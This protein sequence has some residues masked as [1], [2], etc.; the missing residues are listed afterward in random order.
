MAPATDSVM[1]AVSDEKAGVASAM[2]DVTRQVAGAVGV[3]V[4]GSLVASLYSSRVEDA[5]AAL[6]PESAQAASDSVG[7]AVA[8]AEQIPGDAG[9]SLAHA[10]TV[11]YTDALGM[12]LLA[13]AAASF[14]GVALVLRFLPARHRPAKAAGVV[15][16]QVVE[17]MA[18]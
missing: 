3:A 4:V 12:G 17:S 6:P 2:N 1:G 15:S 14:V 16:V 11:A 18:A 10:A 8:V 5:T 7:A 13:G 9:S